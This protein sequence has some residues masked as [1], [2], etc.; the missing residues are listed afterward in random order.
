[1]KNQDFGGKRSALGETVHNP[2]GNIVKLGSEEIGVLKRGNVVSLCT[3]ESGG[4]G[5][6]DRSE[7]YNAD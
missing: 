6:L 4:I 2:D 7:V 1:M 3:S 5:R